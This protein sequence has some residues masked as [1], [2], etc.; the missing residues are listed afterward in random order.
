MDIIQA[1]QPVDGVSGLASSCV[2]GA[3]LRAFDL[4]G[5]LVSEGVATVLPLPQL[6]GPGA[7]LSNVVVDVGMRLVT[8][9]TEPHFDIVTSQSDKRI[10]RELI[11]FLDATQ[12]ADPVPLPQTWS[13]TWVHTTRLLRYL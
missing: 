12:F 13:G 9:T 6:G 10:G 5:D 11:R 1:P 4:T 8:V 3:V 7:V 2:T